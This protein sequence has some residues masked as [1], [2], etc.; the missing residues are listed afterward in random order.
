MSTGARR[1][2]RAAA[3]S[4][5]PSPANLVQDGH[6]VSVH[7]ADADA[8]AAAGRARRAGRAT[9]PP[10][11]AERSEI[12]FLS[13]P[14][15]AV[16]ERGGA[17]SGSRARSPARSS[18]TLSTNAPGDGARA[19]RAARGRGLPPAG[20]PAHRRRA[21]ARRRACWSSWSAARPRSYE[22]VQPLLERLGRATFHLGPARARQHGEAG[23][24][25]A[26]VHVHLGLARG[27]GGRGQGGHR[28]AH[29]DRRRARGRRRQLL[30]RPHGGGH[31]RAR[32]ADAVRARPRRQGRR[33]AP[34]RGARGRRA[35]AGRGAGGAGARRPRSAPASA[36]AISPIW[37]SWSSGRRA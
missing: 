33:P 17:P 5:A 14:T 22:R 13:L 16:V 7:D 29:H 27:A 6:H 12:T 4:A 3:T 30:H 11:S 9:L 25:P 20:G 34:R 24:Q 15:P 31:Q 10:G 36:S 26:R 37:S 32:P 2:H 21:R 28:P 18:S 19:R 1:R 8:P 35:G 23:E